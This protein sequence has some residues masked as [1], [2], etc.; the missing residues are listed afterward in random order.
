MLREII[1]HAFKSY[2]KLINTELL[3]AT[4]DGTYV[5][6]SAF[7]S[8]TAIITPVMDPNQPFTPCNTDSFPRVDYVSFLKINRAGSAEKMEVNH[9]SVGNALLSVNFFLD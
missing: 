2:A 7:N 1:T 9:N 5:Y 6:H 3:K 8:Y 4:D